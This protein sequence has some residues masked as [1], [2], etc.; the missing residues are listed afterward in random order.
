MP[1]EK[2]AGS[3]KILLWDGNMFP[4]IKKNFIKGSITVDTRM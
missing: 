2:E 4:F 1:V 3:S